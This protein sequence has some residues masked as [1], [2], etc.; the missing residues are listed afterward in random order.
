MDFERR[1]STFY[2]TIMEGEHD[3]Y[4]T[5][6]DPNL[7]YLTGF[8]GTMGRLLLTE[9]GESFI[10]VD[11]R[12]DQYARE[13]PGV[14][15]TVVCYDSESLPALNETASEHGIKSIRAEQSLTR[16][17]AQDLM[18]EL[19]PDVEF[20]TNLVA[21]QRTQK[22]EAEIE[23]IAKAIDRTLPTFDEVEAFVEPGITEHEISSFVRSKL[24]ARSEGHAFDPLVLTGRRTENPHCPPSSRGLQENDVLL[25]DM[26]LRV[27][28]YCSDLTRMIFLGEPDPVFREMYELSQK[29]AKRAIEHLESGAVVEDLQ[30]IA[31]EPIE[32]S[33]F[34]TKHS[35][36]HG[37]GLELHEGPHLTNDDETE[38]KPGNIVTIEPGVYKDGVGGGRIEYMMVIEDDG[39][40]RLDG[41]DYDVGLA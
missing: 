16:K 10:I 22:S 40:R 41:P 21:E 4:Y 7:R 32:Q 39:A 3:A 31:H 6:N 33:D 19:D 34:R 37:V 5:Q 14:D 27:D 18:D 8:N 1:R 30:A 13:L 9:E 28:G 26:G 36:G 29:A 24:N 23:T 15:L 25:L 11:P 2:E 12:Y 35:L 17:T 38:L 20:G